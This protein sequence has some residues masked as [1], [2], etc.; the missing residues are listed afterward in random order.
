M[1]LNRFYPGQ[2]KKFKKVGVGHC[3]ILILVVVADGFVP[4]E[5]FFLVV[6]KLFEPFGKNRIA[7]KK[8]GSDLLYCD[9]S[10]C[11][12]RGPD[13]FFSCRIGLFE[14]VEKVVKFT[15]L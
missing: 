2:E 15:E 14:E 9:S 5:E 6:A 3:D 12:N 13:P 1:S 8:M 7:V 10:L 11:G 4:A